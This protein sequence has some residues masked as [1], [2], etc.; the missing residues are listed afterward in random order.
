MFWKFPRAIIEETVKY[1]QFTRE[2]QEI[3]RLKQTVK[4]FYKG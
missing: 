1:S 2:P 4:C 3:K